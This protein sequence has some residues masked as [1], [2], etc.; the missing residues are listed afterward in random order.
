[1][2]HNLCRNNQTCHYVCGNIICKGWWILL[3]FT[4]EYV[5]GEMSNLSVVMS[6][7]VVHS[8]EMCTVNIKGCFSEMHCLIA[9]VISHG[10]CSNIEIWVITSVWQTFVQLFNT[11]NQSRTTYR[12][13]LFSGQFWNTGIDTSNKSKYHH[14]LSNAPIWHYN[15]FCIHFVTDNLDSQTMFMTQ[16]IQTS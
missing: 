14:G 12:L 2:R 5:D 16:V 11:A 15:R 7:Y 10:F 1:M 6:G 8:V 9:I 3:I 4:L 13:C